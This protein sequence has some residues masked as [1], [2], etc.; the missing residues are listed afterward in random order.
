MVVAT[1]TVL[2]QRPGQV[3]TT[4]RQGVPLLRVVVQETRAREMGPRQVGA[5]GV[6]ARVPAPH[7]PEMAVAATH[8]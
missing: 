1:Q 5:R 4:T 7:G 6:A 8:G 2:Q 3:P